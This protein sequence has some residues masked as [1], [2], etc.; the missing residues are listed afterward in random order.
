[1]TVTSVIEKSTNGWMMTEELEERK[2]AGG[3][4]RTK[5]NPS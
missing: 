1:M 2:V 5:K 4:S 3:V